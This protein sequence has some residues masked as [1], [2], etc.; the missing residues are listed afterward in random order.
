MTKKATKEI[1]VI[2]AGKIMED[3]YLSGTYQAMKKTE[4]IVDSIKES[5]KS[6]IPEDAMK[7]AINNGSVIAKY[8]RVNVYETDHKGLA[9]YLND[10]GLLPFVARIDDSILKEN[11]SITELLLPYRL[12]DEFYTKMTPNK[13]GRVALEEISYDNYTLE[14]LGVLWTTE[15]ANFEM[16]NSKVEVAKREMLRC[17]LKEAETKKLLDNEGSILKHTSN[18]GSVSLMKNKPKYDIEKIY[19][20]LG[21]DFIIENGKID[22][23]SLDLFVERGFISPSEIK[24]FRR[25]VDIQ[26]RFSVM[27]QKA[28]QRQFEFFH[29][30][31]MRATEAMR[32][33]G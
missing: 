25:I 26:V 21:S 22:M 24:S 8:S 30:K 6:K 16:Y 27:D 31:L 14:Q 1:E 4:S 20:E 13:N 17:M 19:G 15:K 5:I 32:R 28:E 12:K 9:E 7:M 18:F 23:G 2:G 11:P 10:I 33:V 29:N 3:L